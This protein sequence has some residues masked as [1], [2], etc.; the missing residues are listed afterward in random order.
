MMFCS[1][2]RPGKTEYAVMSF[3]GLLGI[4]DKYH[5]LP[6]SRLTYDV[7][8]GGYSVNIDRDRLEGEPTYA[9]EDMLTWDD[10]RSRDID[11]CYA[12]RPRMGI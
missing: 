1:I 9:N 7:A 2:R 6:W 4:G 8:K 5:P 11:A 12:G 3:G 10:T